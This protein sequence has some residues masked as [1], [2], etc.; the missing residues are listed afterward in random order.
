MN[1]YITCIVLVTAFFICSTRSA[2][3]TESAGSAVLKNTTPT[4]D[5][6][7]R[8]GNLRNFLDKY[9]SPLSA[10]SEDFVRIADTYQVDYR[11]VPAITGVESTFGKRIPLNS[12]NAYGWANGAY[13]FDSWEESIETVT[14]TLKTRYI[15]RG[16]TTIDKIGKIYAPPSNTWAGKVKYFVAKI[17]PMPVSFDI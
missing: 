3:A 7:Y 1:K 14:G 17:D 10:Y 4:V 6:D 5:Y 9:N 2:D 8:V 15:D 13:S 12:Y 16:A 11:L